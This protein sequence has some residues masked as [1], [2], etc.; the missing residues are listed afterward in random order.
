MNNEQI[1]NT[2]Y[3]RLPCGKYLEDFIA[4]FNLS[5]AMGSALKYMWSAGKK[6]GESKEKDLKKAGHYVA[7]IAEHDNRDVFDVGKDLIGYHILARCW[8][9]LEQ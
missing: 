6:D 2:D 7:F 3:Y 9:K 4:D 1:D 5:F 8:G